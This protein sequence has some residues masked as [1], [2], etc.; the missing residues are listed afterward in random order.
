MATAVFDGTRVIGGLGP[1][2]T[3]HFYARVLALTP[4]V[5]DQDHVHLII[6]SNPKVANRNDAVAGRGP[7][8]APDLIASA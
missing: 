5:R 6:D 2:A 4:A 8:P 7:S 3:L 1:D